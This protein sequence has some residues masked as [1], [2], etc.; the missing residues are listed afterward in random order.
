MKTYRVLDGLDFDNRAYAAGDKV[1]I[2]DHTIEAE[3]IEAG[4]IAAGDGRVAAEPPEAAS[5]SSAGAG[6]DG[7]GDAGATAADRA[8]RLVAAIGEL[9][10]DN[11]EQWTSSGKPKTEALEA[12][13]G[14]EG[15]SAA[16]RDAAWDAHRAAQPAEGK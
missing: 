15:V 1:E 14:L 7:R 13:C 4:V 12:V 5:Y 16:E 9:A 3:L 6:N 11:P 2:D 10:A 8:A